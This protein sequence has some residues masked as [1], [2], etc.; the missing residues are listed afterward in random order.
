M[1]FELTKSQKILK[2]AC[3][4]F[5][6]KEL[7]PFARDRQESGEWP[8]DV[9]DKLC[10]LGY[11]GI[12]VPEEYGG[13]A[14]PDSKYFD[15]ILMLEEFARAD[16]A[17]TTS[18]QVHDIICDMFLRYGTK[19]QNDYWLPKL[20]SGEVMGAFALTEPDAGSDANNITTQAELVNGEWVINGVKIFIT[21]AGLKNSMGMVLM[22]VTGVNEKGRKEISS[23]IVPKGTP[24]LIEGSKFKKIGWNVMDTR[25][26]LFKDCR[27]PE[28]NLLGKRGK[29]L[30][31][32]LGGLNLGR[33]DFGAIG[34]GVAQAAFDLSL[35]YAKGRVQFGRPICKN[36]AI[37]FKLADMAVRVETAR[38]HTYRAAWLM[39]NGKPHETEAT[40]AKLVASEMATKNVY[41]GFQIHGG[42]GFMKEYD[43]SRLYQNVKI[44]EIGEGTNEI[45]RLVI[46]RALGC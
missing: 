39:D 38:L 25:E 22:C 45:C 3:Y 29:G 44:L 9:W 15:S 6:Q 7:S 1:Q 37:A 20:A 31:Q 5:A 32:A 27:V 43:I 2:K 11:T 23:I 17:F 16:D 35:K 24:G 4:E 46:S 8:Y 18:L 13:S 33:C 34:T 28:E 36:Q 21:N 30:T 10:E 41:E 26:I 19:E 42:W 40:I 12:V 14:S